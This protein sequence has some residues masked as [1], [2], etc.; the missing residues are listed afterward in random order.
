MNTPLKEVIY[1]Q[2]VSKAN[3]YKAVP[4][5]QGGRRIIKSPELREYERSFYQ[6]CKI[7]RNRYISRPFRLVVTVFESSRCFDL[8][9]ALK[10]VLDCLQYVRAIKDDNLCV[11]IQAQKEIAPLHPRIEFSII[12]TEPTLFF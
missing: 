5:G 8:D 11:A 12:E 3:N 4:D 9:N 7:Y 6:Q 2:V 1:G 10:T